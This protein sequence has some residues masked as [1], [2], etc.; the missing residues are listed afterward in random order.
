MAIHYGRNA[1]VTFNSVDLSNHVRSV[2]VDVSSEE[3]DIT[4]MGATSRAVIPGLRGDS[5]TVEFYV[6]TAASSVDQTL[7]PY[8]GSTTGA[9]LVVKN[10]SAAVSSTNPSWTMTAAPLAYTPINQQIGEA[11]TTTV[12]FKPTAGG[13]LA[14]ATS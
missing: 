1:S 7:W 9:T 10:D 11:H 14:R 6:D 8:V 4:A 2:T 5:V 12:V 13:A 3:V